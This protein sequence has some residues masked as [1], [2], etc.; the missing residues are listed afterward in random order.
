M[1]PAH[2][3]TQLVLAVGLLM[4]GCTRSQ[5]KP[6]PPAAEGLAVGQQAPDIV[7]PDLDGVAFR[8]SDYRGQVVVLDF[9]GNW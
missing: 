3:S 4:H 7:G 9:W 2:C 8:L 1:R 5:P 6:P